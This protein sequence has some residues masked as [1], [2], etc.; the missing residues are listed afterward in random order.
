[1]AEGRKQSSTRSKRQ[2]VADEAARRLQEHCPK[3]G[4]HDV[5]SIEPF[6]PLHADGVYCN[7]CGRHSFLDES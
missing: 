6:N 7:H 1:M 2:A 5:K 3:C 4:S